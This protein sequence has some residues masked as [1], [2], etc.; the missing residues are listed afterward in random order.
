MSKIKKEGTSQEMV[1]EQSVVLSPHLSITHNEL[2]G[3]AANGRNVSLLMKNNIDLTQDQ[4]NL[5]KSILGEGQEVEIESPDSPEDR[6]KL[7]EK[8][9]ET[10][11]M[12]QEIQ[13]AVDAAKAPLLEE[14]Q[15][16]KNDLEKLQKAL[17]A[18]VVEKEQLQKALDEV[19]KAQEA[20]KAAKR[21]ARIE[22]CVN[23]KEE[24]QTL[25]DSLKDLGDEAFENVIKALEVKKAAIE[26]SNLFKR[27]SSPTAEDAGQETGTAQLLKSKYASK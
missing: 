17:E 23:D 10:E 16:A 2:Q 6:V 21:L 26:G 18:E 22:K 25:A 11:T 1:E 13:K 19:Q 9:K 15:K 20:E 8:S 12:D 27:A 24:A 4:I 14:L 5:L 7:V 3:G